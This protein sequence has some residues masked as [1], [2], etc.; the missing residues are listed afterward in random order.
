MPETITVETQVDLD[1]DELY[2]GGSEDVSSD[3]RAAPGVSTMRGVDSLRRL[4]PLRAGEY[5][6]Q[7]DNVGG[8]YDVG[9]SIAR[10]QR[11]RQRV[12]HS[13]VTYDVAVG[14]IESLRQ[15]P[16]VER[17]S[18]ELDAFG[19]L[20]QLT[21]RSG[22]STLLYQ[23]LLTGT[24]INHL[25]DAAGWQRNL[26]D[27]ANT[28]VGNV[29]W[30]YRMGE[31]SGDII[32]QSGNG[33]DGAVTLGAGARG[34]PA[35]D[36]ASETDTNAGA[37]DGDGANTKVETA[38]DAA[39]QNI[40][41]GGG[42]VFFCFN[43]DSDGENSAG[44]VID[45]AQWAIALRD[46]SGSNARLYF[47]Q[48][49]SGDNG[50]WRTTAVDVPLDADVFGVLVYDADATG[51][52][53]TIYLHDPTNGFRTLTVGS[54]LTENGTPTGT[55]TTDV[56]SAL[57]LLNNPGQT[58]TFD[59]HVG[60]SLGFDATVTAAQ[61]KAMIARALNAPR[62]IDV[63]QVTL[64]WWWLDEFEN[65]FGGLRA[66]VNSEGP[67]ALVYE[68]AT[69]ACVYKDSTA[70]TTESR[71]TSI[72]STFRGTTTEPILSRVIRYD[73][74]LRDIVNTVTLERIERVITVPPVVI[75][76][77][78][79]ASSTASVAAEFPTSH[80][81]GDTFFAFVSSYESTGAASNIVNP[82]TSTWTQIGSDQINNPGANGVDYSRVRVLR[83]TAV[84]AEPESESWGHSGTDIDVIIIAV[85]GCLLSASPV[86]ASAATIDTSASAAHISTGVTTTDDNRLVLFFMHATPDA[87]SN[88]ETDITPPTGM[89]EILDVQSV[90]P[91]LAVASKPFRAFGG[92]GNLV[93][94]TDLLVETISFA[95]AVIPESLS[96]VWQLTEELILT[97]DE[98]RVLVVRASDSTPFTA[99][100][101]PTVAGLDYIVETGG[102]ASA[103]TLDRT[104]GSSVQMTIVAGGGGA[105]LSGLRLRAELAAG[106]S[107]TAVTAS[108]STSIASHGTRGLPFYPWREEMSI[109]N[110]QTLADTLVAQLKDPRPIVEFLVHARRHA[111]AMTPC[112]AREISDRVRVLTT[113]GSIDLTGYV[114][115]I[116]QRLTA[117]PSLETT[118]VVRET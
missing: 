73:D 20:S 59:G 90:E 10:G 108:D 21:G 104:S 18:V 75:G 19:T 6:T 12:T 94:T 30:H 48:L 105:T 97:A 99:A 13:A 3:V 23:A 114:E 2:G 11:V 87:G 74:G 113:R 16:A 25:L 62:H 79:S 86:D 40:F 72:Q 1:S 85:R 44:R 42:A 76:A 5:R 36:D 110:A 83:R 29:A 28:D 95:I 22:V 96:T 15:L 65:V 93:W 109:A 101:A 118:F 106:R 91:R 58:A 53:P 81:A 111:D 112:L 50:Q 78:H 14:I 55:R 100:V 9:T 102:L 71:S 26:E 88:P 61:A 7:L 80:E 77:K 60:R 98:T 54:G 57:V 41:D 33:N 84:E 27:Y 24:A 103:I 117:G 17:Q 32:D 43:A 115:E 35:L 67:H 47:D 37:I 38:D 56:G 31:G 89:I 39:F 64:E 92:T 34:E 45:K 68:D 82:S 52:N 69:G 63:G 51:N 70:R 46:E 49:F 8:A 4:I 66:L 107:R 116:R